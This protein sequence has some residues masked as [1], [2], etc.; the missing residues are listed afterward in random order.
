MNILEYYRTKQSDYG[1]V[2]EF[3]STAQ[4]KHGKIFNCLNVNFRSL[5]TYYIQLDAFKINDGL[6]RSEWNNYQYNGQEKDKHRIQALKNAKFVISVGDRFFIT[7]KG[8]LVLRI[9]EDKALTDREKWILI[10]MLLI[11]FEYDGKE[12]DLIKSVIDLSNDLGNYGIGGKQ[13]ISYL[14]DSMLLSKKSDIFKKD[15]FWLITFYKDKEFIKLF[16]KS[17]EEEKKQ[18]Y[19]W[20]IS[21]SNDRNSTDCIAH[22]FMNGGAYN[23]NMFNEDINIILC[24]LVLLTLQDRNY[25]NFIMLM[26]KLYNPQINLDRINKI[27]VENVK[28]FD[29]TYTNSIGKINILLGV[30]D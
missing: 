7:D 3:Q 16:L 15:I 21:C 11:D 14:K 23:G 2:Q 1:W 27:I 25:N 12:L 5:K 30:E 22:K 29:E 28:V 20:V 19:D 26:S 6:R 24:T 10:Y 8:K 13:L 9:N 17:T 4:G 18:L